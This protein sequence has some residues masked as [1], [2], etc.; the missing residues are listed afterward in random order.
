[1]AAH[2]INLNSLKDYIIAWFNNRMSSK[3][4]K[5]RFANK[6]NIVCTDYIIKQRLKG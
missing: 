3:E 2:E 6:Y 5:E 4:I 1:M